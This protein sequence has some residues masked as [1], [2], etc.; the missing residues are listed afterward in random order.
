MIRSL[1]ESRI[2]RDLAEGVCQRI[3]RRVI[4]LLQEMTDIQLLGDD[5]VLRNVWDEVCAQIQFEESIYWDAYEHTITSLVAG[6]FDKL[7][8]F[9]REAVWLRSPQG[10]DWRWK[11]EEER[12]PSPVID[13]QA[14][15]HIVREFVYAEAGRWS[16]PQIRQYLDRSCGLD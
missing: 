2:V 8:S 1:S 9:E 15:D 5:S 14:I 10:E 7:T 13:S 16:N 12:E 6:E 4:R 3:T 11:E